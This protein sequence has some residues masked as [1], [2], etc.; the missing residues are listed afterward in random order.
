[1]PSLAQVLFFPEVGSVY[2]IWCCILILNIIKN[3]I[4]ADVI[5]YFLYSLMG[6]DQ[7]Y[8]ILLTDL[9]LSWR[10]KRSTSIDRAEAALLIQGLTSS[11][12]KVWGP[13][14]CFESTKASVLTMV[15]SVR[16]FDTTR[17]GV[18]EDCATAHTGESSIMTVSTMW[19]Y[20][21]VHS[22]FGRTTLPLTSSL[23][24]TKLSL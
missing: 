22:A 16:L 4:E 1:M 14:N 17:E 12:D 3:C 6:S 8:E 9:M 15:R 2:S 24:E 11:P 21:L 18:A 20:P 5:E 13:K 10:V 7:A 23:I 19:T